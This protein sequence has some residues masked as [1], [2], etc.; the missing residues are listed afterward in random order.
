M[1]TQGR[2]ESPFIWAIWKIN[3]QIKRTYSTCLW[4][5]NLI[6]YFSFLNPTTAAISQRSG[7]D[8]I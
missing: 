3:A 2:I 1:P 6:G 5:A 7:V 4:F 8:G